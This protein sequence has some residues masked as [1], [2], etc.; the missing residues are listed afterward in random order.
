[1]EEVG[2]AV[3]EA[4]DAM[5]AVETPSQAELEVQTVVSELASKL[6]QSQQTA[7]RAEATLAASEEAAAKR[8]SPGLR[9]N[10]GTQGAS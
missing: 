8:S 4:V 9:K 7:E 5:N 3:D 10:G 2:T 6:A 1:M